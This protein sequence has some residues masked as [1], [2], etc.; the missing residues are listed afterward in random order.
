MCECMA[1]CVWGGGGGWA[2]GKGDFC[3]KRYDVLPGLLT[4]TSILQPCSWQNLQS[5][6]AENNIYIHPVPD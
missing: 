4:P 6:L 3:L 5:R 1:L 2:G